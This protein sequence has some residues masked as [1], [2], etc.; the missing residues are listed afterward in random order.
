MRKKSIPKSLISI[1]LSL[2]ILASMTVVS[3]TSTSAFAGSYIATQVLDKLVECGLRFACMASAE[4]ADSL[5][6]ERGKEAVSLITQWAFMSPEEVASVECQ[7]LCKEILDELAQIE[8][9]MADYT[10]A[11]QSML[12]EEFAEVSFQDLNTQWESDV[13][14]VIQTCG[15]SSLVYGFNDFGSESNTSINSIYLDYMNTA[16][17]CVNGEK[18]AQDVNNA[19]EALITEIYNDVYAGGDPDTLTDN[20][21]DSMFKGGRVNQKFETAIQTLSDNLVNSTGMG[22]SVAGEAAIFSYEYFPYSHQQYQYVYA[23]VEK[24]ILMILQMEMIYNEY[25][26]YQGEYLKNL[27][28]NGEIDYSV[29]NGYLSLQDTFGGKINY[30]ATKM[31]KVF[32]TQLSV[33]SSLSMSINDYMKPEDAVSVSLTIDGYVDQIDYTK[34]PDKLQGWDSS[35]QNNSHLAKKN[36]IEQNVNFHRVMAYG[37]DTPAVYYIIDQ[38][39]F[40]SDLTIGTLD[41]KISIKGMTDIHEPS[42]DY[43]NLIKNMSDGANNFSC[44]NKNTLNRLNSLIN[45]NSFSISKNVMATYL[46]DYFPA[47]KSGDTYLLTASYNYAPQ[48]GYLSPTAYEDI[49]F[50]NASSQKAGTALSATSINGEVIQTDPDNSTAQGDK[51]AYSVILANNSDIYSQNVHLSADT[52]IADVKLT[53][54]TGK[55]D[56]GDTKEIGNDSSAIIPSSNNITITFKPEIGYSIKALKCIRNN[57]TQTETVIINENDVDLLSVDANGYYTF[58]YPMPYSNATFVIETSFD[59]DEN[60]SFI[61]RTYDDLCTM[62]EMVNSGEEAYIKGS[63]ILANDIDCSSN[64]EW[65]TPIGI[66]DVPFMG[67]FDGQ[68]Y[69]ITGLHS[70]KSTDKTMGLFGAVKGGTVKNVSLKDVDFDITADSISVIT[71]EYDTKFGVICGE[72]YSDAVISNCYVSGSINIKNAIEI[73]GICGYSYAST[74][75]RCIN[76]CSID[77]NAD[78]V[79]GICATNRGTV[80]HCA[81]LGSLNC[82]DSYYCGGIVG[83]TIDS[84]NVV[85]NSYNTGKISGNATNMSV[86]GG[87]EYTV[88]NSYYLDNNANLGSGSKGT[89]KTAEQFKSGEVTYLLNNG[90]TDGMQVWYQDIDNENTPYDDK[91]LFEGGTVY[92]HSDGTYSNYEEIPTEP[93]TEAPTTDE[94]AFD[95]DENGN[96]IIKTYE[97]LVTL[98]DKIRS[99]YET[100]GSAT[101]ILNNNIV[102]TGDS[103][104]TQGIGCVAD[105]KPFN[106]E[107][108]GNGYCIIGLNVDCA[109][110]G[111][112]FEYVGE[113]GY[114]HD[115]FVF[116]CDFVSTSK[117]A[118]GIVA[119]NNGYISKCISGVSLASGVIFDKLSGQGYKAVEYNS[120]IKGTISGGI[121]GKNSGTIQACRNSANFVN[122]TTA[123]GITGINNGTI[124]RCASN[125]TVGSDVTETAGGFAG[126]NYGTITGGY[127]SANVNATSSRGSIAGI[128]NS[129]TVTNVYYY[130]NNLDAVGSASTQQ[131][132][133]SNKSETRSNMMTDSFVDVLNSTSD[134]TVVWQRSANINNSYPTIKCSFSKNLKK[135]SDFGITVT[136]QMHEDL[137]V[138]YTCCA[139]GSECYNNFADN[140][141]GEILSSY[142]IQLTD[143]DGNFVPAELWCQGTLTM[144]VPVDSENVTMLQLT[145]E[146]TYE[147]IKPVS[148]ENGVAEFEV[149]EPS[150][151]A[152]VDCSTSDNSS[153]DNKDNTST[154]TDN[155]PDGNTGVTNT[156]NKSNDNS[157]A[158]SNTT[159]NNTDGKVMNTGDTTYTV[160]VILMV[161]LFASV[162]TINVAR[163]KKHNK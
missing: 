146:G 111:G 154:N 85:K 55:N 10:T 4:L 83:G 77:T 98:S 13:E 95:K 39:Q 82:T 63:Y 97:D 36:N 11:L 23:T 68:G 163:R 1:L 150:S 84:Y 69:T 103:V 56:T 126:E 28:D 40:A 70:T 113:N 79:G 34:N 26:S 131:L 47:K 37:D 3:V 80:N 115:L 142:D 54:K 60:G 136:G 130:A 156:G 65:I 158:K 32:D 125:G 109:E 104:W 152:I 112:L 44:A 123:G 8:I 148:V 12:S 33:T 155:K 21:K 140:A 15:A 49:W 134:D 38:S 99:D 114:I 27:Y 124:D 30:A 52:G 14:K 132:D 66:Y 78:S 42:C 139:E 24:Q 48:K 90:V 118:G 145:S 16:F 120:I 106:G 2:C 86:I 64:E 57:A 91:P 94:N 100:Y 41:H 72:I 160:T 96:F 6:N 117:V 110:Y 81:N 75:E 67:T 29:W 7:E 17:A 76:N 162:A 87:Y 18:T 144:S 108:I 127:N 93:P 92:K 51:H 9:E 35:V 157:G 153:D 149:Y 147:E 128:N 59:K 135:I 88:V 73:G 43:M 53:A 50:V 71:K 46:Y 133:E 101:Y 22:T 137:I 45:T 121:A 161:M 62:A 129:T 19:R 20:N 74:I 31:G 89:V 119:V 138:N 58:N 105:N 143:S 116:D 122:S 102:A 107:F 61:I 141:S 5:E 151:F 25:L 159:A